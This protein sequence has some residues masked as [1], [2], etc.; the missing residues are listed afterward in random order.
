MLDLE[1]TLATDLKQLSKRGS[2]ITT[3]SSLK[4]DNDKPYDI[5]SLG[6]VFTPQPI[7]DY[8][9]GLSKNQG[10]A[11]E[12]S[13]GAGI[14]NRMDR[15][16]VM[17]EQDA[18]TNPPQN[19]IIMDF[20]DYPL[21]EKFDTIIGNPPY[22]RNR[23]ITSDTEKKLDYSLF[24]R[25]A[26]LYLFFI[27]KAIDHL[28]P[29]GELIFITPRDFIKATGASKLNEYIYSQG[30]ITHFY[31]CGDDRIFNNASPNCA[32]WRF[33]KELYS[34]MTED[35]IRFS[36]SDGQILFGATA[37]KRVR[38]YFQVK[39]GAVSG[40]DSIYQHQ[41]GNL[42]LVCSSTYKTGKVKRMIYN[43]KHPSLFEHK[44]KLINRKIRRFREDNWWQ[45]GRDYPKDNRERIY[46]NAKT[47][48]SNPFFIHPVKAYDGSVLALFPNREYRQ[49]EMKILCEGLNNI[50]WR[51]L[52]FITGGRLIFNQRSLENAPV[53]KLL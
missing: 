43:H 4:T 41:D 5:K 22:V 53:G 48:Q 3:K 16:L 40:A 1:H 28:T 20:F 35:G 23:D 52:G 15:N 33:V 27:K 34:Y 9:W 37:A 11:L 46:V 17:L 47:R 6:Q 30:T 10:R 31:D 29:L 44:E 18:K 36:L 32:I 24:D 38:D 50:D 2:K 13:C 21:S 45:W 25:H 19:A 39:V 51:K 49:G 14:F 7:A 12:P 42:E 8:M 26:N